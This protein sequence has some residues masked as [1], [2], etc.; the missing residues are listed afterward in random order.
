MKNKVAFLLQ[1]KVM[2]LTLN[3]KLK[4]KEKWTDMGYKILGEL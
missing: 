1:E 3:L 2:I 4:Q